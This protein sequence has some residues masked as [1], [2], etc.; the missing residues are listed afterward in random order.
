MGILDKIK[1]TLIKQNNNSTESID[2]GKLYSSIIYNTREH[3]IFLI[4][5]GPEEFYSMIDFTRACYEAKLRI[6]LSHDAIEES[7][8]EEEKEDFDKKLVKIHHNRYYAVISGKATKYNDLFKKLD[9]SNPILESIIPDIYNQCTSTDFREMIDFGILDENKFKF[10]KIAGFFD[11]PKQVSYNTET[12]LF[13]NIDLILSRLPESFK[14]IDIASIIYVYLGKTSFSADVLA[15][16]ALTDINYVNIYNTLEKPL[17]WHIIKC[18][19]IHSLEILYQPLFLRADLEEDEEIVADMK[20]EDL[21]IIFQQQYDRFTTPTI[22][23]TQYQDIDEQI[24]D[25]AEIENMR[26]ED[27]LIDSEQLV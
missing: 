2:D 6:L 3:L 10:I 12:I 19:D 18:A 5:Y 27:K 13:D 7:Y 8:S 11:K 14:A 21:D 9:L 24:A 1:N 20:P 22:D 17:Y 15:Q 25:D 4:S 26:E 23:Y 16:Y